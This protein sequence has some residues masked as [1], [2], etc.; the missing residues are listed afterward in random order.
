VHR[1]I[2]SFRSLS[3]VQRDP[4]YVP[5]RSATELLRTAMLDP[6]QPP[7]IRLACAH[8]LA[9]AEAGKTERSALDELS[10]DRCESAL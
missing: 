2:G 9:R 7:G 6:Q 5:Y 3:E 10:D 4:S 8:S 1:A